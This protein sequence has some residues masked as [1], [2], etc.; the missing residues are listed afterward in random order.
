MA[1]AGEPKWFDRIFAKRE[2]DTSVQTRGT[3][4]S[5]EGC[6]VDVYDNVRCEGQ[7]IDGIYRRHWYCRRARGSLRAAAAAAWQQH[8][9]SHA[10][11]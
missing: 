8:G 1:A 2:E 6:V 7:K 9:N 3:G 10:P 5:P 4:G 11:L